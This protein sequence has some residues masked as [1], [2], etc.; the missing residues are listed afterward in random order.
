MSGG[1][2]RAGEERSPSRAASRGAT[3]RSARA[4]PKASSLA[5]GQRNGDNESVRRRDERIRDEILNALFWD[6]ALP[7]P[8][9]EVKVEN[10]WVTLS[11]DVYW[12]YQKKIAE[13]DVRQV[14]GVAGVTNK[15]VLHRGEAARHRPSWF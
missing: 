7:H 3:P 10:G 2:V 12:P 4:R 5:N 1:T 9:L 6:L 11:G 15:L 8:G 14:S 13:K